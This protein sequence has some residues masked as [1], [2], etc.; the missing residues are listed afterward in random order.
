MENDIQVHE[1]V[2]RVVVPVTKYVVLKVKYNS[3]YCEG[4]ETWDW[5]TLVETDEDENVEVISVRDFPPKK[6]GRAHV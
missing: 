3:Y 1:N 2:G 4:P 5:N 6:I